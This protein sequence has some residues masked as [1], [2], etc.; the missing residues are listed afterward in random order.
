[1][2]RDTKPEAMKEQGCRHTEPEETDM[3]RG[4]LTKPELFI[5]GSVMTVG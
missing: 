2:G 1:M 4:I 3:G 5:R